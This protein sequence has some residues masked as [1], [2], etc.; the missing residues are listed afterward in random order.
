MNASQSSCSSGTY[1]SS[2]LRYAVVEQLVHRARV[3]V[4]VRAK[5]HVGRQRCFGRRRIERDLELEHLR[6]ER[7]PRSLVCAPRRLVSLGDHERKLR[8]RLL[9]RARLDSFEQRSDL[10][11]VAAHDRLVRR[12]QG[13]ERAV[14]EPQMT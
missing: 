9:P 7:E 10:R 8:Q 12:V 4:A 6:R 13:A 11:R 3:G 2:Q 5:R 1:V 14:G